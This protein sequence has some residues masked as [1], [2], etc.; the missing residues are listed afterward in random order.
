MLADYSEQFLRFA[1]RYGKVFTPDEAGFNALIAPNILFAGQVVSQLPWQLPPTVSPPQAEFA[2]I[3][4]EDLPQ[5]IVRR[6]GEIGCAAL[7]H[8]YPLCLLEL[9]GILMSDPKLLSFIGDPK[10]ETA[11]PFYSDRNPAGLQQWTPNF[12]LRY[13]GDFIPAFFP[14]DDDRKNVAFYMMHVALRFLW[15]HELAHILDGH[16]EYATNERKISEICLHSSD[17]V[18]LSVK[19]AELRGLE[20]IADTVA[21]QL[22]LRGIFYHE[23]SYMPKAIS[24]LQ[25]SDRL[26]INL[27]AIV[28]LCWFWFV[29]DAQVAVELKQDPSLFQWSDHPG[30]ISRLTGVISTC[31]R[32]TSQLAD[33]ADKNII[34]AFKKLNAE[35]E[36][37]A[38]MDRSM[39]WLKIVQ[40]NDVAN[41]AFTAPFMPPEPVFKLMTMILKKHSYIH[42]F[43]NGSI[44]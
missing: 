42:R 21:C 1:A 24:S 43:L 33:F 29:R 6:E 15:F 27:T 16:L 19:D 32:L 44:F 7:Y 23:D 26:L 22:L 10:I 37:M 20:M 4:V 18:E 12:K 2:F 8:T 30:V 34:T 25:L 31:E 28:A 38:S 40:A 35:C 39:D 5:G 17:R 14:K 9:F 36:I 13:W 11:K 41:T 3:E